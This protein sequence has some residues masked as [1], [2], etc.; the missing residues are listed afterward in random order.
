MPPHK[1][2][3]KT[4]WS[5][6]T[7]LVCLTLSLTAS[8]NSILPDNYTIGLHAWFLHQVRDN[9]PQLSAYLHDGQAEKPFAISPLQGQ[10]QTNAT[11]LQ[12]IAGNIYTWSIAALCQS[13][14]QWCDRWLSL[15]PQ[16]MEI[17]NA[18]FRIDSIAVTL[19][20]TTYTQL[21]AE[22]LPRQRNFSLTFLTPT[23]FRHKGHHLPLPIPENIFH[24]Y[25]R[26]WNSFAPQ[27]FNQ[28]SF[29]AWV[30]ENI[31]VLYYNLTCAKT[32]VGKKDFVT[33]F[34]EFAT[35]FT[36]TVE[37]GI[38]YRAK[39]NPDFERLLYALIRL[40]PY[41]STGY[42]TT[43]GLGQTRLGARE[44][45]NI[46]SSASSL[47]KEHLSVRVQYLTEVFRNKRKSPESD[48]T[49]T[50]ASTWA[51]I[52]A[53]RELGESLQAIALDLEMP[54][55]TVKS[56]CKLARKALNQSENSNANSYTL[57]G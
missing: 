3:P 47:L 24:S 21:W 20:P 27:S 36:G 10:F 55:E 9:N 46:T 11:N 18:S 50:I 44:V 57:N 45:E 32:A 42:K 29:L 25:L 17:C 37:F 34:T 31:F 52:L 15:P 26:R 19:P 2:L 22:S 41:C 38:N 1:K 28:D 12:V 53:R 30:D 49:L 51:T 54:Y 14:S 13:L 8:A 48:R 33:G 16:T 40:A 7:E 5:Q 56:Y 39:N 4:N 6:D 35:G 43:F 23:S